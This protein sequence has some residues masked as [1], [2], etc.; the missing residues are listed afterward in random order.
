MKKATPRSLALLSMLAGGLAANAQPDVLLFQTFDPLPTGSP[1]T[2]SWDVANHSVSY[3]EAA[4]TGGSGA[5]VLTAD[6]PTQ[7]NG[8]L[9]YQYE[10][11][12]ISA[13]SPNLADYTLTFDLNVTGVPLN[14]IPLRVQA[15]ENTGW[16]G[17]RTE[18]P[19]VAI[20]VNPVE[21]WQSITVNFGNTYPGSDLNPVAGTIHFQFLVAGWQ[22]QNGGPAVGQQVAIDNIKL[23]MIPEPSTFALLGL[24]A[25]F[26]G[27]VAHR[28]RRR[29]SS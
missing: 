2:W 29:K 20:P 18:T 6:F 14:N 17:T 19:E 7:W 5:V 25:V 4:G 23:E 21:G 26:V 3:L 15:W 12:N 9:A 13:T 8:G 11:S 10:N 16:G 24:G 28:Q 1:T 27:L 22:L